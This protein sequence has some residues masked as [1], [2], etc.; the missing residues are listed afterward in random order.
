M[1]KLN[2][3]YSDYTDETDENY[4]EGKAVNASSSESYDGTPL[5]AEFMN[6]VNAAHIAMYEKAHGSRDGIS[7]QADTQKA[8]QFA[9][10]VAKY[11][12]D[13]VKAHA[14]K[15]GLADGVHGATSEATPG[16]IVSR[17]EFGCAKVSAPI[18]ED[19]I[20]RKK[21]VDDVANSTV[22]NIV[23]NNE[24]KKIQ[25]TV[26]KEVSDVVSVS[27]LKEAMNLDDD[28]VDVVEEKNMSAV[29][30]N[31]V[32]AYMIASVPP[33]TVLDYAGVVI[34]GGFLPCDGRA[35][36]KTAYP[37]LYKALCDKQGV[38]IYGENQINNTFNLPDYRE[39]ATVGIGT[40]G[41]GVA[42]H[43]T[44]TL[45]EFKDDQFKSHNH[46]TSITDWKH[47]H[48]VG[49][50]RA[51]LMHISGEGRVVV[52]QTD[53]NKTDNIATTIDTHTHDI[54]IYNRGGKTTHGKQVGVNKIIKY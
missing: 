45:G 38:C 22:S 25:K 5:L 37:S 2:Q 16:Q 48:N 50:Q 34:P 3:D 29:T 8:S 40:R 14:D 7:G 10:A 44:Y 15:R 42:V 23:Y 6:D 17:D 13:K 49:V 46:D 47:K 18:A 31:A 32:Y 19:D 36:L 20:A 30:S 1:L 9:D 27:Q 4:P 26:G 21:E 41:S 54:T 53:T 39:C 52:Y 11:T 33:G 35:V 43:D 24:F 12:D 28:I 51:A